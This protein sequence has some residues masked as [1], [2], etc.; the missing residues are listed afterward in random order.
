MCICMHVYKNV[1]IRMDRYVSRN[2][3]SYTYMHG[4]IVDGYIY[5]IR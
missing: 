2:E 5:D 4:G 1:F 3:Y